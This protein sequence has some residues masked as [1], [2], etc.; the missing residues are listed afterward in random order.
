MVCNLM[1]HPVEASVSSV[2]ERSCES[3]QHG[4]HRGASRISEAFVWLLER[5]KTAVNCNLR[6]SAVGF[7]TKLFAPF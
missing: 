1:A 7:W 5:L 3:G 4:S 2:A 6:H